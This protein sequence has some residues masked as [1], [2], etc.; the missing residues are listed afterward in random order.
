M[1]KFLPF[2]AVEKTHFNF[3]FFIIIFIMVDNVVVLA[4]DKSS[5]KQTCWSR[6]P[7]KIQSSIHLVMILVP[8]PSQRKAF[9]RRK[10][11]VHNHVSLDF[12][13]FPTNR[14]SI[15]RGSNV[16]RNLSFHTNHR[17]LHSTSRSYDFPRRIQ[18]VRVQFFQRYCS[19]KRISLC[20]FVHV[21]LSPAEGFQT[22]QSFSILSSIEWSIQGTTYSGWPT[23]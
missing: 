5:S 11:E 7:I 4:L 6:K 20:F 23:W 2:C 18:Q 9:Q 21:S 15:L 22:E 8:W 17:Q 12:P 1:M 19:F 10:F 14:T 3:K 13:C 16:G